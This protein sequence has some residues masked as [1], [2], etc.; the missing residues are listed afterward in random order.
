MS[1]DS[2][3]GELIAAHGSD[4]HL[5]VGARPLIRVYGALRE[6]EGSPELDPET[7]RDGVYAILTQAQR[8]R[9]EESWELD[10]AYSLRGLGRFRL[11]LF[12]QR[13]SIGAV[14]R[15]IPH[16]IPPLDTLE[17]P[18]VVKTFAEIP[19]G[20]VL[21]TGPTGS[22]KST[23][24]AAII[25][26]IN[27]TQ[28]R[29]IVTIEDP[30][31]FLHSHRSSIVNQ[32]EVGT[33]TKA[34][35]TALRQVLRQDPDVIMVGEMRDFETIAAAITAAETGHL[36]FATLHT[37]DAPQAIDRMIDVFPSSQQ[38]QI[39]VQ[40]AASLQAIL[41]QQL[42]ARCDQ[43]GR[44]VAVEVL[45]A[46]SAVRNVIREAKSHQLYSIMQS[47]AQMGMQTMD[48]ALLRLVK[49]GHITRESA[50]LATTNQRELYEA[51]GGLS[52]RNL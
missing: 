2:L 16:Q 24:L 49:L 28:R 42:I 9:F 15:V 38:A 7:I 12:R 35:A 19:K 23:T 47:S 6:L 36:V 26:L 11:N 18:P 17:L 40:L 48:S 34:F 10:L 4:L 52:A 43:P 30:I 37:Q 25:D 44:A 39:R 51:M 20:L 3:L 27:R 31:E 41:T 22:G 8:E 14:F 5:S 50:L 33:D 1:I 45:V 21:V 29:H 46:T 13:S 32:R